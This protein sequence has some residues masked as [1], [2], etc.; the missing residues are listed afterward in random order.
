M[1]KEELSASLKETTKIVRLKI[2][3]EIWNEHGR[4]LWED[5]MTNFLVK[6]GAEY[7]AESCIREQITTTYVLLQIAD[8]R[9]LY[10]L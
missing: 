6:I 8:K 10:I 4:S 5:E 3:P 9:W 2:W 7:M 1:Y